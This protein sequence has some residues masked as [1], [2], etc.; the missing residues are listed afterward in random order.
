[1]K[2]QGEIRVS[3]RKIAVPAHEAPRV[4]L[5]EA[6]RRPPKPA[7]CCGG[8]IGRNMMARDVMRPIMQTPPMA[9]KQPV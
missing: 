6:M 1:M 4:A 7:C 9:A 5:R 2:L 3:G 8:S